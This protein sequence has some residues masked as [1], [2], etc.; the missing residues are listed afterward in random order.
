MNEVSEVVGVWYCINMFRKF[1]LLLFNDNFWI[2]G[3]VVGSGILVVG[4]I[5]WDLYLLFIFFILRR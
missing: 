1:N 3:Y 4:R 5:E 2:V